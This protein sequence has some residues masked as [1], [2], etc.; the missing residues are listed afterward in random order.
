MAVVGYTLLGILILLLVLILVVLFFPISY[1]I[2]GKKNAEGFFLKA[3]ATWLFG[4][5]RVFYELPEPKEVVIKIAW[6]TLGGSKPQ[7]KSKKKSKKTS[8]KKQKQE[9]A[10]PESSVQEATGEP[11]IDQN[12]PQCANDTQP[13]E[14]LDSSPEGS[15]KEESAKEDTAKEESAKEE[16]AKESA[17]EASVHEDAAKEE[18]SNEKPGKKTKKGF[19]IGDL[20]KQVAFYKELWEEPDTKPFV[21]EALRRILRVLKNLL[22]RKIT[23]FIRFGAET[24]DVT[25]YVYG[26]YCTFRALYP[27]RITLELVPD[28]EQKILQAEFQVKGWFNVFM[29][30]LDA[31][32]LLFDK[33]LKKIKKALDEHN[34]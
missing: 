5:V 32:C 14:A 15:A 2:S 12:E 30:L 23:G 7:K 13:E 1:R 29:I 25:G 20:K 3:K 17:K 22:P 16:S 4:L 10:Q 31:L 26:C 9:G 18:S 6:F 11:D 34:E 19:Q 8:N 33:R 21:K 28:F 24:P 27:K